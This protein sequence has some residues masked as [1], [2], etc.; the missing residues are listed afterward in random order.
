MPRLVVVDATN[1]ER[2]LF[3]ASQVLELKCPIVVAL[4]MIDMARRD[5]IRTLTW[6]SCARNSDVWSC[7]SR[8]ATA[9]VLP[10]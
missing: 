4:N 8:P 5:G 9:R 2:N 1:L 10:S 7:R 3:L 6:P